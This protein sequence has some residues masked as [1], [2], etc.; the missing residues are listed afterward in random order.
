MF[1]LSH[2]HSLSGPTHTQAAI[3]RLLTAF[4]AVWTADPQLLATLAVTWLARV[5]STDT[6]ADRQHAADL[7]RLARRAATLTAES[8]DSVILTLF[9][10]LAADTVPSVALSALLEGVRSV[11]VI[12]LMLT[13]MRAVCLSSLF[14]VV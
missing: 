5:S 14:A 3:A 8:A 10:A 12:S 13:N 11:D 1:L 4:P 9:Q 7:V 2:F 6:Q